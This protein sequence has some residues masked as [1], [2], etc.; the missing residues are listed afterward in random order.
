[1]ALRKK[2]AQRRAEAS[3]AETPLREERPSPAVTQPATSSDAGKLKTGFLDGAALYPDGS[4]E[5]AA[6]LWRKGGSARAELKVEATAEAYVVAGDF[7]A[8]GR[9]LGKEDFLVERQGLTLRVR[10]NHAEPDS[11]AI[12]RSRCVLR[13]ARLSLSPHAPRVQLRVRRLVSGLDESVSL[14][15]DAAADGMTA[16]FSDATLRITIPRLREGPLADLVANLTLAEAQ[17]AGR[18]FEAQLARLER[19]NEEGGNKV[20]EGDAQAGAQEQ[21]QADAEPQV[22]QGQAAVGVADAQP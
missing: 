15:P 10:G 2:I 18:D 22:D 8:A 6:P 16:D 9:Y 5:A 12:A 3:P 4:T 11:C 1:M 7:R 13:D 21:A 19:A 17:T 14:P 20:K